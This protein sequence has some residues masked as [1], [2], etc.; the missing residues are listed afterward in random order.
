MRNT[1]NWVLTVLNAALP[2][3]PPVLFATVPILSGEEYRRDHREGKYQDSVHAHLIK[4][5]HPL[6]I[7]YLSE[8]QLLIL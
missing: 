5:W 1:D 8:L 2:R 3:L 6:C 7:Y 4:K